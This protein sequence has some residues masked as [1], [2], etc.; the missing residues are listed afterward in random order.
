MAMSVCARHIF[1]CLH[2]H[3]ME[4]KRAHPTC[5]CVCVCASA[6]WIRSPCILH[7]HDT[8]T[9]ESSRYNIRLNITRL[10][11]LPS[12][13]PF[14]SSLADVKVSLSSGEEGRDRLRMLVTEWVTL[15]GS[16]STPSSEDKT[17]LIRND[18]VK[19][20][21]SSSKSSSTYH[22]ILLLLWQLIKFTVMLDDCSN[23]H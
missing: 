18:R 15:T 21:Q 22:H 19:T 1:I 2:P 6:V 16:L 11:L 10:D 4:D 8:F 12:L 3:T 14:Q 20:E 13:L 5:A 17:R 23:C 7:V 9:K